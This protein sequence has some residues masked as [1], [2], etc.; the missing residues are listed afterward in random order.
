MA[1]KHYAPRTT[2]V[3]APRGGEGVAAAIGAASGRVGALVVTEGA[4]EAAARCSPLVV[5]PDDPDAYARELFAALHTVD[6]AAVDVVV[7]EAVPATP[8]WW[9]VADRLARAS[10]A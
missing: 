1:A 6:A 2:V 5:L 9:A 4:R 7:I 8:E 10:R 3:L